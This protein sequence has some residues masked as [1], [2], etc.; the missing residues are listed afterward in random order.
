MKLQLNTT[1]GLKQVKLSQGLHNPV[2]FHQDQTNLPGQ[3]HDQFYQ[4]KC[5]ASLHG[6]YG[7]TTGLRFAHSKE[8]QGVCAVSGM[9]INNSGGHSA[10][11]GTFQSLLGHGI[12]CLAT[13]TSNKQSR[14]DKPHLR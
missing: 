5:G 14:Q 6:A 4:V 12:T 13:R 7:M 3:V 8:L 10:C 2:L 1:G 9:P 11:Q